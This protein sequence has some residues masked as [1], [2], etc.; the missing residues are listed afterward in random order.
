MEKLVSLVLSSS[1]EHMQLI[2]LLIEIFYSFC[3]DVKPFCNMYLEKK[4]VRLE[5]ITTAELRRDSHD[6]CSVIREAQGRL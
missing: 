3:Y 2:N 6:H 4:I 5:R 1:G